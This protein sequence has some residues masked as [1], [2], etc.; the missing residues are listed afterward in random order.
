MGVSDCENCVAKEIDF[1]GK[2]LF[3]TVELVS[4]GNGFEVWE[5]LTGYKFRDII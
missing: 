3:I 1:L 5:L 2:Y 4:F